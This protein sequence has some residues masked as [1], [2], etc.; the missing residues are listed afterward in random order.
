M[1]SEARVQPPS[2]NPDDFG[3]NWVWGWVC[4]IER[5]LEESRGASPEVV[6]PKHVSIIGTSTPDSAPFASGL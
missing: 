5:V 1:D 3:M 2:T 4:T 6:D